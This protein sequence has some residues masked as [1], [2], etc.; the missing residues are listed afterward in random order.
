MAIK[1]S[2]GAS[3]NPM[4]PYATEYSARIGLGQKA[5]PWSPHRNRAT[6]Y[7]SNFRPGVYFSTKI[8]QTD[9]Q[10]M[11]GI[12][13][14]VYVTETDKS[15][16]DPKQ[17]GA[18][19]P[20]VENLPD[21]IAQKGSGFTRFKYKTTPLARFP[22]GSGS[23]VR[24]NYLGHQPDRMNL[25]NKVVGAKVNQFFQYSY[26]HDP[27]EYKPLDA[28]AHKG[29]SWQK[30]NRRMDASEHTVV[31]NAP[32]WESGKEKIKKVND[33]KHIYSRET[34]NPPYLHGDEETACFNGVR[35]GKRF[36]TQMEKFKY[37]PHNQR[38]TYNLKSSKQA[39]KLPTGNILNNDRY[40]EPPRDAGRFISHYDENF[41]GGQSGK[42]N[43][44]PATIQCD[45]GF[46]KSTRH[47]K[48]QLHRDIDSEL[49][50]W[51][52]AELLKTKLE[53]KKM[54]KSN[55]APFDETRNYKMTTG[56][57]KPEMNHSDHININIT[58]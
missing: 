17:K 12:L 40:V 55:P 57:S 48:I 6:G 46:T 50:P 4:S 36:T 51:K 45:N 18:F 22:L 56:S 37:L 23:E 34:V 54:I 43:Y 3:N 14:D 31:F 41:M 25:T 35:L 47:Y 44:R 13:K 49:P 26:S 42:I 53:K 58:K 52:G 19:S 21:Q 24:E 30:T 9:N 28:F 39:G 29:D 8:D 2:D 15:F 38:S 16:V 33:S 27:V 20:V 5:E 10:A 7:R 11:T 1:C 32:K